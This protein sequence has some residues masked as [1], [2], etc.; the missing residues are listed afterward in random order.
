MPM[1]PAGTDDHAPEYDFPSCPAFKQIGQF[2]GPFDLGLIP[3]GAY[4]PRW[5][6]SPMHADPDD[7]VQIFRDTKC[8]RAMAIHWGTWVLTDEDVLEPPKKLKEALTKYGY[9]EVGAFDVCDIGE[10][11]EF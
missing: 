1:L 6:M 7:A 3:I 2:R 5:F 10:S 4:S 11:R 9:P 8:K